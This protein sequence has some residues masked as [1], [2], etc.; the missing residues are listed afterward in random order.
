[1]PSITRGL[2]VTQTAQWYQKAR[3]SE[4]WS[5]RRRCYDVLS[6]ILREHR[7]PRRSYERASQAP[8]QVPGILTEVARR[9]HFSS[10][11]PV[12][13]R[14][15]ARQGSR[16]IPRWA[17]TDPAIRPAAAFID[18]A[19]IVAF[20]PYRAGVIDVADA[21]DMTA[22]EILTAYLR[23]L[24]AWAS[25]HVTLA[26]CLPP[27]PPACVI[28]DMEVF[29]MRETERTPRLIGLCHTVAELVLAD[30]SMTP[31]GAFNAVRDEV[32]HLYSDPERIA[33]RVNY[34]MAE[35]SDRLMRG[36]ICGTVVDADQ[37]RQILASL[38]ELKWLLTSGVTAD[39]MNGDAQ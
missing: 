36:A 33:D 25:D 27:S 14:W 5:E 1:M 39:G 12:Y 34:S 8:I 17:G 7:T 23:S 2:D 20:W 21:F 29:A 4:S 13:K 31:L 19:K 37:A 9:M 11:E 22:V 24:A 3:N 26:A 6:D 38:N 18:E 15:R 32:S 30:P 16:Q 28:E 35:L 10:R